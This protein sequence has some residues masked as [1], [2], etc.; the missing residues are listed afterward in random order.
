MHSSRF[1][2]H[3]ACELQPPGTACSDPPR[4]CRRSGRRAGEQPGR[5]RSRNASNV[6]VRRRPARRRRTAAGSCAADA[7]GDHGADC[8][9]ASSLYAVESRSIDR[10]GIWQRA[11][12]LAQRPAELAPLER[13]QHHR[14]VAIG[15]T[16]ATKSSISSD[17]SRPRWLARVP[18]GAPRVEP[19][20][21]F[22]RENR[23]LVVGPRRLTPSNSGVLRYGSPL[24]GSMHHGR[25]G[26]ASRTPGWPDSVAPAES[27]TKM[28]S[29]RAS[30]RASRSASCASGSG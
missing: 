7:A 21:G 9:A 6:S 18:V 5:L 22:D 23:Q 10:Y 25:A 27:P 30:S 14:L 24:S 13:E 20:L 4:R 16:C 19:Q 29:R 28:P 8:P 17:G 2:R 11:T 1:S 3:G 26:R 12:H 15:D